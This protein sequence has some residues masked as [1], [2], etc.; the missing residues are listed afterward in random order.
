MRVR[1]NRFLPAPSVVPSKLSTTKGHRVLDHR[2][3]ELQKSGYS[4]ENPNVTEYLDTAPSLDT[5]QAVSTKQFT[6]CVVTTSTQRERILYFGT[7]RTTGMD[8]RAYGLVPELRVL[9]SGR[10]TWRLAHLHSDKPRDQD[11]QI[12]LAGD[13]FGDRRVAGL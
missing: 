5:F 10:P 4:I 12:K 2:A 11:R 7:T 8:P 9:F 3:S 1:Y 6:R 13:S